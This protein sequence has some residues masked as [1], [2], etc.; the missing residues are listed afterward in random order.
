MREA[1]ISNPEILD[2]MAADAQLLAHNS[3]GIYHREGFTDADIME[4][5]AMKLKRAE[6]E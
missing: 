1:G 2:A 3:F 4:Y 5:L 6:Q